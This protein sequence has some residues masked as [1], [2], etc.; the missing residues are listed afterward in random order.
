[1]TE[2]HVVYRALD[3]AGMKTVDSE[4][5]Q[6]LVSDEQKVKFVTDIVSQL[7]S[8]AW[9]LPAMLDVRAVAECVCEEKFDSWCICGEG[10]RCA[11]LFHTV[12]LVEG[13]D[14]RL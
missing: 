4:P 3:I 14:L 1:M 13:N 2:A 12:P 10:N 9:L 6:Q 7:V 11:L 5:V 8:E